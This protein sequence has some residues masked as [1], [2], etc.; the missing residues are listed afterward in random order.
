MI[1][2]NLRKYRKKKKLDINQLAELCGINRKTI[3]RAE[4]DEPH[5]T[6][7]N[8]MSIAKVLQVPINKLFV[9]KNIGTYDMLKMLEG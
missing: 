2:S 9:N 7:Q 4:T 1:I 6:L 5:I 8:A 3:R